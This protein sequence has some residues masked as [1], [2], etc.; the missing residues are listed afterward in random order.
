[1]A[2]KLK[3][4][5]KKSPIGSTKRQLSTVAGLGLRKVNSVSLLPDSSAVRGMVNKVAH[6]LHVEEVSK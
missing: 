2:K 5:L 1:M 6:L 4:T 3:I